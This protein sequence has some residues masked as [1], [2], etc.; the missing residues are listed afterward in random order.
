MA[1]PRGS[2]E[3]RVGILYFL[4][5]A[6]GDAAPDVTRPC[7]CCKCINSLS[8]DRET[9]H[10]HLMINGI[11]Q[12]YRIWNFHGEKLI[13]QDHD[14]KE[15]HYSVQQVSEVT[16]HEPMVQEMLHDAF[17]IHEGS[18]SNENYI[19]AS[20]SHTPMESNV[21]DFYRLIE[22]GK[23]QLYTGCIEFSK[24]SFLVELFQLKVNGKWSDKSFT[25]LLDFL[26]RV[27][28]SEAQVPKS[29]YEAKKLISSL[30]LHYEKI[31]ACPNDCMIYWGENE[32]EQA[33][34]VCNLPRWKNLQKSSRRSY[35]GG[36]K[37]LEVK[38]S[39]KVFW[40][41]PLKPRLQRLFMSSKTFENMQWHFKKRVSDGNL[42]HPA[43]SRAW[44]EFDERHY[45]F[46]SDP[47]NVRLGL[48]AD[49]FNPFKNQSTSHSTWPIVL[50]PYN[51]PPWECMKPYSIILSTL[52]PGPKEP[53]NDIDIYLRPLLT[54]LKDLWEN[55]IATFDAFSDF[56][57][58][59]CLSGWNTYAKNACP[60]CVDNTNA[61][62]LKHGKKWSFRGH[63]RF[64][65]PDSEMR[66]M[67][68]YGK[69]ELRELD[70]APLLG[71][72][73]LRMTLNKNVIFGKSNASKPNVRIKTRSIEQMWRKQS[74]FFSLPYW[75]F[76]LI[77]HNL[78]P[79]HIEKNVCDNIVGTLL[80]DANKSKDNYAARKD[81]KNLG[82]MKQLWP[83]AQSDGREYLPPACY[84]MSKDDKKIFCSVLKDIRVPDD[85]NSSLNNPGTRHKET[86]NDEFPT[87]P[88]FPHIGRPTKGLQ[89][90]TLDDKTLTQAHRYIL[91]NCTVLQ[92]YRDEIKNELKRRHRYGQRPSNSQLDD[93]VRMQFPE[94]FARRVDRVNERIDDLDLRVLSRGP[95]PVAF[96]YHGFNIN[97]FAFRTVESEKKQKGF[98]IDLFGFSM[99]NFSRLIHTGG[100]EEHEPFILATQAQMVY[101][102]RDPKEED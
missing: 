83:R 47:R 64:L 59:G 9:V 48:T 30:G 20:T 32:N 78:D 43:D 54:Q 73:V 101:Y 44:K 28:P 14:N 36:K 33:Y 31:H 65:P 35:K 77:R 52:I 82:I 5:Y 26:R 2:L 74:I 1:T 15:L 93:M 72:D 62:Y 81:L 87:L 38:I 90:V 57:G 19:G 95:N 46:A 49:G 21:K 98:K 100:R 55:G 86:P 91:S 17:G 69:L 88:M 63:H 76:N 99:L 11:L 61:V 12:D 60:T 40:Y 34:K 51:L 75:E 37:R 8:H 22:E 16:S 94:W 4:R 84:A 6:F 102:V 42:R 96:S 10:E 53:G 24:L 7:P 41:F 85:G 56:P 13:I 3:Y 70:L 25:A 97:G 18:T 92:P 66:T 27:L 45:E 23:Q 58:L 79:M 39:A 89:V 50:M 71:S 68:S 29:F 67:P 80:D